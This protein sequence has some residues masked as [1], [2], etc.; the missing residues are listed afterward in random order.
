MARN[1]KNESKTSRSEDRPIAYSA[2][3]APVKDLFESFLIAFMLAFVLRAYVVE[4]FVIPTGSMA[5]SL[6][7][8]HVPIG[9]SQ[10]GYHFKVDV[11]TSGSG[12]AKAMPL[13]MQ[14][15][16]TCPM[17]H[18][19][20]LLGMGVRPQAGD[21]ILIHK[22]IYSFSH[23]K[24]WDVVVFKNPSNPH[25]NY[26]KR[27]VGLPGETLL[28]VEGNVYTKSQGEDLSA[29]GI[30]RKTN[31]SENPHATE[32]QRSLWQPIYHSQYVPIDLGEP[33][34]G[35]RRL[36]WRCPWKAIDGQ[37]QINGHRSYRYGSLTHGAIAFSFEQQ[38]HKEF[39]WYPYN[40][41]KE[42]HGNL[43]RRRIIP[44]PIEEVRIA[45]AFEP[46]QLGLSL[47]LSTTARL[48]QVSETAR[49][50]PLV[51]RIDA[52]GLAS[53]EVQV[54]GEEIRVLARKQISPLPRGRATDVELW[55]VDQEASL[56]VNGKC[57]L[58]W[59]F[60]FDD[61]ATVSRRNRLAGNSF[62]RI[63][64]AVSGSP[65]TLHRIQVDRDIV[66]ISDD[67][68]GRVGRGTLSK[69]SPQFRGYPVEIL[70]GQFFCL[71][72]NSPL[73]HDGRFWNKVDPWIGRTMLV[74]ERY[75]YGVVPDQLMMGKAFFVYFPA[76]YAPRPNW[77]GILPNFGEM[78]F[79]R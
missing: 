46:D 55:Y 13:R 31:T 58:K 45:A 68:H 70:E 59:Y 5:P 32:I 49:A 43:T 50:L 71:G 64:I 60:D 44:H 77:L 51:G 69:M 9:C 1:H 18:Q 3:S 61:I 67:P 73:S 29:W 17:C 14:Q 52:S 16:V 47:S 7:G 24:R 38:Y 2:S 33:G 54:P 26:I 66:Y 78:R 39:D 53:L 11:P 34:H 74:D 48:D 15:E 19:P 25:Q 41:L 6:L 8:Q 20:I 76:P 79:I 42:Q 37:W 28:I 4:A 63:T 56:W 22:Y 27:L 12:S 35:I 62:P 10:C 21:R 72:D 57:V 23:P 30:A 75:R 36:P 40:Q 65:V